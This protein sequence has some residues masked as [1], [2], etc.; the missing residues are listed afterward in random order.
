M[1]ALDRNVLAQAGLVL[2]PQLEDSL[3]SGLAAK[4]RAARHGP[5]CA[6]AHVCLQPAQS[7]SSNNE[8]EQLLLK[9]LPRECLWCIT[10]WYIDMSV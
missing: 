3:D 5:A 7:Q 6:D 2:R 8:G 9:A 10:W 1:Y 4:A